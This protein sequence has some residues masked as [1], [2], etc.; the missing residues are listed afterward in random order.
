[1]TQSKKGVH[2]NGGEGLG[3]EEGSLNWTNEMGVLV[4]T[5]SQRLDVT[6]PKT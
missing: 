5:A 1:M 6:R 4:A 2:G 3:V